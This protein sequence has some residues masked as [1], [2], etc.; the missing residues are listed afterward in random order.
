MEDRYLYK[1]KLMNQYLYALMK[2]TEIQSV[3][4]PA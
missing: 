2:W 1:T 3:N 4:A